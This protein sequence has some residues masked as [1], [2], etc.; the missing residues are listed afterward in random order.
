MT[1]MTQPGANGGDLSVV[2]SVA[3]FDDASAAHQVLA[4]YMPMPIECQRLEA[5]RQS[6]APH[7]DRTVRHRVGP[8]TADAIGVIG[9]ADA[10][11]NVAGGRLGDRGPTAYGF[12]HVMAQR[13]NLLF[14]VASRGM[15]DAFAAQHELFQIDQ[16]LG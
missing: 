1:S 8:F 13:G 11:L 5:K 3:T 2:Q 16:K 15:G 6:R 9:S 12:E 10:F 14:D 7:V 4:N